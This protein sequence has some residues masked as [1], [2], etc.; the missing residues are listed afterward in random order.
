MSTYIYQSRPVM[1]MT[2]MYVRTVAQIIS[3][4]GQIKKYRNLINILQL[5]QDNF[6]LYQHKNK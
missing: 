5:Y 4:I 1:L 2:N 3:S 6:I